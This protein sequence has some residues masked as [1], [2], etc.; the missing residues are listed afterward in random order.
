MSIKRLKQNPYISRARKVVSR[1]L[2]FPPLVVLVAILVITI[3]PWQNARQ[4]RQT[5]FNQSIDEKVDTVE[6]N[7]L[8]RF[9]V[10]HTS[11]QSGVGLF[12]TNPGLTSSQWNAFYT[13]KQAVTNRTGIQGTGF[14]KVFSAEQYPQVQAL[15][16]AQGVSDFAI[17]PNV[18]DPDLNSAVLFLFSP[19]GNNKAAIGFNMLSESTRKTALLRARDTGKAALTRKV[20]LVQDVKT[21]DSHGF[22]LYV[23]VFKNGT[24]NDSVEERRKNLEG[25]VYGGFR[26][27]VLFKQILEQESRQQNFSVEVYDSEVQES[28]LLYKTKNTEELAKS[29]STYHIT[30]PIDMYGVT[31][32]F[33]FTFDQNKVLSKSEDNAPIYIL[34]VGVI[35]AFLVFLALL[36]IFKSRAR[37]LQQQKDKEVNLAKDELLSLASH[38]MRTPATGVKQYLGMV[39]Q[40]FAGEINDSQKLLLDKAY[41]SNERQLHVINQILHLAKLESGRIVLAKHSTDISELLR[42]IVDEQRDEINAHGHKLILKV[43]KKKILLYIDSHM[44]RMA[45]ENILTNAIKYTLEAGTI[46]VRLTHTANHVK[47]CI[48]D[49]GIGIDQKQFGE[50]FKQ[51]TRL[52]DEQTE[53]VSGT[54]V[55]LYLA[56][57]LV[58][59]HSGSLLVESAPNKG[60]E[61][62]IVLPKAKQKKQQDRLQN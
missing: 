45:I 1:S 44:I 19:S 4:T 42:D 21:S 34:L 61:F 54:G 49:S 22:L 43:P 48:K 46:K 25:F 38:Q 2:Y 10:Y 27:N 32:Q 5:N 37:E 9:S 6:S 33:K 59:L 20:S 7:L 62:T 60:S 56:D 50:I 53:K 31:W 15:M 3:W 41:T 47:I 14:S 12:Q 11:L 16:Q 52:Y 28:N 51:F 8:E 40:G 13:Y 57:Q 29:T 26:A 30:K 58:R 36:S 35:T 17:K 18:L 39:L 23:P 24:K 55:G